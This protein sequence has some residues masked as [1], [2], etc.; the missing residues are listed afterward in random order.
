MAA[1]GI[2]KER[3]LRDRHRWSDGVGPRTSNHISPLEE[4]E[5]S[6]SSLLALVVLCLLYNHADSQGLCYATLTV[7]S[8]RTMHPPDTLLSACGSLESDLCCGFQLKSLLGALLLLLLL[9]LL[10]CRLL[11]SAHT[12]AELGKEA[13]SSTLY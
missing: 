11:R 4:V 13:L 5:Q 6:T 1:A 3:Y 2:K 10:E 12:T 7:N 9:L 8:G